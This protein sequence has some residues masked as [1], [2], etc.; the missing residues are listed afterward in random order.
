MHKSTVNKN[1]KIVKYK[2]HG[3][4]NVAYVTNV[5]HFYYIWPQNK[6]GT[7]KTVVYRYKL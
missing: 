4:K 3:I 7:I 6:S 5:N 2:L 1:S